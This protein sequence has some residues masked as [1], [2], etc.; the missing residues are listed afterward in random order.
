VQCGY[1]FSGGKYHGQF[2]LFHID[3]HAA[4][5]CGDSSVAKC[6]RGGRLDEARSRQRLPSRDEWRMRIQTAGDG[7]NWRLEAQRA[8]GK[9]LICSGS[10]P[11]GGRQDFAEGTGASNL[12]SFKVAKGETLDL[13]RAAERR[14]FVRH[15][16]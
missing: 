3:Y 7:I 14:L 5:E 2:N 10:I 1:T 11:N 9:T 6:G 12:M 15:K 13:H 16:R 8:G 4:A